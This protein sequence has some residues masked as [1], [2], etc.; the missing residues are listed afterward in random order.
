MLAAAGEAE[1]LV[2]DGVNET[3]E[4]GAAQEVSA[5]GQGTSGLEGERTEGEP[6]EDHVENNEIRGQW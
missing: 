4:D 6:Q 2:A 3:T 5:E 1:T